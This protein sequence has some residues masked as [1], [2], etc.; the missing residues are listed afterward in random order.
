MMQEFSLSQIPNAFLLILRSRK[1]WLAALAVIT[2][3]VAGMPADQVIDLVV[4]LVMLLMALI[5]GEDAAE[6][7]RS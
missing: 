7:L 2:S 5:A 1:F 3:I 6:K 4:K